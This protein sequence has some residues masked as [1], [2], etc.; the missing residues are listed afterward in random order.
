M[1]AGLA[2]AAM[3]VC[4]QGCSKKTPPAPQKPPASAKAKEEAA[5]P[6]KKE[7]AEPPRAAKNEPAVPK[8]TVDARVVVDISESMRGFTGVRRQVLTTLHQ[9][10][11]DT[12]AETGLVGLKRC[13]LG[14][15]LKCEKAPNKP[16]GYS[17]PRLYNADVSRLDLALVRKPVPEVVDPDNPPPPDLLDE[18]RVTVLI[19]DGMQASAGGLKGSGD[20]AA[21]KCQSGADPS[22]VTSLL[23]GRVREGYG[24]WLTQVSLPF[25]GR[26][27]TERDCDKVYADE[28]RAHLD[29]AN[30][31]PRWNKILF[32]LK[33]PGRKFRWYTYW[34][35][36]PLLVLVMSRDVALG[37]RYHEAMLRRL[38]NEPIQP[39]EMSPDEAAQGME[40]A[41]LTPSRLSPSAL[42]VLPAAEQKGIKSE[43]MAEFRLQK[44]KPFKGGI[45]AKIWC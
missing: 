3:V 2:T 13:L 41:P 31:N 1:T 12:F 6:T 5:A 30:L 8:P 20:N 32:K 39:G 45:A 40:L 25:K 23:R 44:T 7:S 9:V 38:R 27:F 4:L 22:C 18:T 16:R 26:H 28:A 33:P 36:K 43:D 17:H 15:E 34:G 11:Q 10:L 21:N 14:R 42:S 19:T 35:F 24:M 37:R 29:K